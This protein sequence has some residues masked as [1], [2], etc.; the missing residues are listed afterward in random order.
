[1]ISTAAFDTASEARRISNLLNDEP[2]GNPPE[3]VLELLDDLDRID[4]MGEAGFLSIEPDIP[5]RYG[6]V[7]CTR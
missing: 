1:M 4:T 2:R 6:L 5:N 3:S 7:L